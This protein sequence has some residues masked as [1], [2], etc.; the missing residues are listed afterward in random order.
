MSMSESQNSLPQDPDPRSGEPDPNHDTWVA[1]RPQVSQQPGPPSELGTGHYIVTP[2]LHS[3]QADQRPPS[4][5]N[6]APHFI[7]KEN[8]DKPAVAVTPIPK[9]RETN[10]DTEYKRQLQERI[11]TGTRGF[12]AGATLTAIAVGTVW[13][14]YSRDTEGARADYNQFR[15]YLDGKSDA[16]ELGSF[17]ALIQDAQNPKDHL[18]LT[19]G[20]ALKQDGFR[21][22]D[23]TINDLAI[24]K[25]GDN[26]DLTGTIPNLRVGRCT[27]MAV[28]VDLVT[29]P[30]DFSMA[31]QNKAD[32]S[33]G[34]DITKYNLP[35]NSG[36]VIAVANAAQAAN[37]PE[38]GTK[39]F[40]DRTPLGK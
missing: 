25:A 8:G 7:D 3:M 26:E 16:A 40:T 29:I 2:S 4:G 38:Y 15:A 36:G 30:K 5:P 24:V 39:C 35:L 27:L 22:L 34:V 10:E 9:I 17:N 21:S 32:I 37:N 23:D 31:P 13:L 1:Y 6:R 11:R 28:A 19:L 12:L 18:Q 33:G 20:S 14:G